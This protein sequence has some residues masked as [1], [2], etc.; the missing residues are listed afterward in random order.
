VRRARVV[1]L[2]SVVAAPGVRREPSPAPS[3]LCEIK[4]V[5]S[6]Y[7]FYGAVTTTP[8]APL[9]ALLDRDHVLVGPEVLTA[10]P[11]PGSA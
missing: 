8:D 10:P 11:G 1:E 5:E 4:A 2:A 6:G 9:E 7:P 3:V